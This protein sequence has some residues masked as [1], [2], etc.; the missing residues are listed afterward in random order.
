MKKASQK[1]TCSLGSVYTNSKTY[2][3]INQ[4][5]KTKRLSYGP[6]CRQFEEQFASL[7]HCRYALLCSSGTGAIHIILEA[8]KIEYN[9]PNSSEVL[10]PATTFV[11]TINAVI[12]ADL[13]PVFVDVDE[14]SF[15]L[16]PKQ[17]SKH[18]TPQTV[19]V[20][21]VHL[22]G[23]PSQM[24][25]V[26]NFARKNHLLV[27]E[28]C[29]EAL[30]ATY[31]QKAVGSWGVAGAFSTNSAHILATGIGGVITTNQKKLAV[32]M[33]S[34]INHGR[35]PHYLS[36]DD[37]DQVAD[38]DLKNMIQARFQFDHIG[39]SYRLSEFEAAVGLAQLEKL[40]FLFSKRNNNVLFLNRLLKS[41]KRWLHLPE[42]TLESKFTY[43][44]YPLVLTQEA[45]LKHPRCYELLLFHL[46]KN[47]IETRP[48]MPAI[49]QPA[50]QQ[51]KIKQSDYPVA[52]NL[53]KTGFYVGCHQELSNKQLRHLADSI[54]HF[55]D[56][57][58]EK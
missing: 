55:I 27:I 47:G 18:L 32:L 8:L 30:A 21:T 7:H 58:L 39:F 36:I 43:L 24:D 25:A 46:E 52:S 54:K 33:R 44:A 49:N 15:N 14:K 12:Q 34:L 19:A 38:H 4:I 9:W 11:A 37:D 53:L 50:Y 41:K 13:K 31:R 22:F 5:I 48:L 57:Q 26:C 56:E 16:D 3:Y 1:M 10:V 20:L 40:T 45:L 28:D 29:C 6:F 17:L 2:Q 51:L 42:Q 23:K 35:D